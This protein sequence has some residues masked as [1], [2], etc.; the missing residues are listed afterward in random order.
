MTKMQIQL[1]KLEKQ[2]QD[3]NTLNVRNNKTSDGAICY[4]CKE[5]GHISRNCPKLRNEDTNK[6]EV[7]QR[8]NQIE[9]VRSKRRQNHRVQAHVGGSIMSNEA[10]IFIEAVV[11]GTRTKLLIDTG[12]SLTLDSKK[13]HNMIAQENLPE[14]F[15]STQNVFNASGN[16]LTH[17]GKAEFQI[18][19]EQF[20][21][22]IPAK[23]TGI[24][25]EGILG[26]NFLKKGNG[27]IDL[28]SN[29]LILNNKEYRISWEG[30]IGCYRV[31][32]ATCSD[33]CSPP[34]SELVTEAKIAEQNTL[35]KYIS[36]LRFHG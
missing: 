3:Q 21:T 30:S 34:R 4:H 14:L 9:E 2:V 22:I 19:I 5:K 11:N 17:Y 35:A 29:T 12:A 18:Q 25:V 32:A 20:E 7:A 28:N 23:V 27:I 16:A 36:K 13:L 1:D 6:K 24:T 10:G 15:D 26:V 33:I 31:I 8:R